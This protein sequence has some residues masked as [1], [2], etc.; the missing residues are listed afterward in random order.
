VLWGAGTKA[1][2]FLNMLDIFS[3]DGIKYVVDVNP[4]K[5]GRF[6]PR[7]ARKSYLQNICATTALTWSS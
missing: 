1:V 3:G 4:R 7:T 5:S 2:G 6:V